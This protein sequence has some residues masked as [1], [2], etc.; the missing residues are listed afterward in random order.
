MAVTG[1][2]DMQGNHINAVGTLSAQTVNT[3]TLDG[4][5]NGGDVTVGSGISIN[6]NSMSGANQVTTTTFNGNLRGNAN[7]ATYA[8]RVSP[9]SALF[10]LVWRCVKVV[11]MATFFVLY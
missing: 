3:G 4:N 8:H 7:T 2:L 9:L 5:G 10:G 6:G 1:D 11:I